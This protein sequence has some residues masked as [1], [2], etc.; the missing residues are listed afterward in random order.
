M[1]LSNGS[2]KIPSKLLKIAVEVVSPSLTEFFYVF[3]LGD[4]SE[5]MKTS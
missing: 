2:D 4:F 3:A 5:R 1:D